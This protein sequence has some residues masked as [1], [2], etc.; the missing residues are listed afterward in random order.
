MNESIHEQVR[1]RYG[2]LARQGESCCSPDFYGAELLEGLPQEAGDLSLGCG[3]PLE[4]AA[5]QPGETVL[6]L[7]SGA[8]IDCFLA[9]RAVGPTGRVIGVDMTPAMLER[10]EAARAR[11]GI[12]NVEFREGQIEALPLE[13]DTVDVI[14]SNCVINLTPD[15]APV[16]REAFR[17]LKPGGRL[18]VSDIVSAGDFAPELMADRERWAECVTGAI[19]LADYT[20]LMREAGLVDIEVAD[21]QNA[22]AIVTIQPG[23]PPLF[24]ARITARKPQG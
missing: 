2:A 6:D 10:A 22:D 19:P 24:S 18:A 3:N 16:F 14:L 13:A 17:V 12:A 5:L 11:M 9:A 8:G 23:M 1:E 7:G 21:M 15:K 4:G 20:G